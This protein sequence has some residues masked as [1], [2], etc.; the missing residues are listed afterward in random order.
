MK[1]FTE[2]EVMVGNSI[3]SVLQANSA[4]SEEADIIERAAR[5]AIE[6]M[7]NPTKAMVSAG[8]KLARESNSFSAKECWQIM[9][10][11]ALSEKSDST[12]N[13]DHF[14][15]PASWSGWETFKKTNDGES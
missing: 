1:D 6:A 15:E 12:K 3:R 13:I 14:N 2:M 9:I 10:D 4:G 11:A 5:A 7:A 8:A